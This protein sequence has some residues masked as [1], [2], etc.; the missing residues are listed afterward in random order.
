[1]GQSKQSRRET[2]LISCLRAKRGRAATCGAL[3]DH[4]CERYFRYNA[5]NW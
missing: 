4:S 2:P 3:G 5:L 1:M